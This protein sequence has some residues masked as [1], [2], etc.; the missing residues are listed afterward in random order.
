M[1]V[2][3]KV[4]ESNGGGAPWG[5]LCTP[6]SSLRCEE[7]DRDWNSHFEDLYDMGT[8]LQDRQDWQSMQ[9]F[10]EVS[11]PYRTLQ[12]LKDFVGLA[13]L[14]NMCITCRD[15]RYLHNLR[16]LFKI[17]RDRLGTYWANTTHRTG[18]R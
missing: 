8:G 5:A 15:P 13:G 9:D 10:V 12:D 4:M 16:H 14:R 17:V 6:A 18:T 7:E 11:G 1:S 3:V 2:M